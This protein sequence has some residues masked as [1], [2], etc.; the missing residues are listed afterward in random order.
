MRLA[1][2]AVGLILLRAEWFDSVVALPELVEAVQQDAEAIA[3]HLSQSLDL[4]HTWVVNSSASLDRAAAGI[5]TAE[6]DLFI[7]AFQVWAEDFYLRPLLDALSSRPLAVWCYLPWSRLPEKLSFLQVLRGSGPVGTFEGLGTLRNLGARFTFTHG[8]PDE[9]R[10]QAELQGIARAAQVFCSLR[11]ARIGL[12]PARNEQMQ[13]TF[14]DEFRLL[15]ELGPS[16]EYLSVSELRRTADRLPQPELE[17]FIQHLRQSYPIRGVSDAT[18]IQAARASLGL[19]RLSADH[20]LD[21]VSFNDIA[22]ETHQ[23]LGLRPA[24]YPPLF[25]QAG[26]LVGLEGDLGAA[27]ALFILDRLCSSP[28]LFVEIWFWDEVEN[29]LVGGH[30]GPQNP[31]VAAPRQAWISQDYEFAQTDA[32]EGAHLQF[33]ARPGRVALLQ[34]R[35]TPSGWQAILAA[36]E[37]LDCPPRLEGYPH[38]VIRLDAPIDRFVRQI[39]SVGSTQH[40]IMAYGDPQLE[41]QRLCELLG[42]ALEV[43]R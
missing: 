33:V 11:R 6:V 24:L 7:L 42:V 4:Q 5:R 12:L 29:I 18:L 36:G 19:A 26:V 39:A 17:A 1:K 40:W 41:V 35:G 13:S 27:T 14:V 15:H 43:I 9:P 30:A 3:H 8:S 21:V 25:N 16:V 2:P 38:A 31:A 20:K 32:T 34:L 22:P 23:A 28:C 10:L 37:A